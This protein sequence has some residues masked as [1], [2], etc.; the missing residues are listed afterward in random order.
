MAPFLIMLANIDL[1]PLSSVDGYGECGNLV[2][3]NVAASA[4]FKNNVP[5]NTIDNNL[6]TRWSNSASGSW[7][8]YDLGENKAICYL[9]IAW[10]KGNQ[11][12]YNFAIST[13]LDGSS[14][15][16]VHTGKSGKSTSLQRY[17]IPDTTTR[18]V[19][20]T[21]SGNSANSWAEITEVDIYGFV[22]DVVAP[23]VTAL[24][25]GGTFNAAQSIT[26]VA[27]EP[28]TIYFTTDSS[29]PTASSQ[30]YTGPLS[31]SSTTLLNYLAID[32]AGNSS[33]IK[34]EVY[35]I[36]T[37]LPAIQITRPAHGSSEY[38]GTII[39]EGTSSDN[40]GGSGLIAV[41][42]SLD[43]GTYTMAVPIVS[44]TWSSGWQASLDVT[45]EGT[46]SVTA[47][48]TDNAG[49][50][51]SN[52][53][54]IDT[55]L[56]KIYLAEFLPYV[57]TDT[58]VAIY[59]ELDADDFVK[60]RSI[61]GLLDGA[62]VQA[63][64]SLPGYHGVEYVAS[65]QVIDNAA[66]VK[67]M[68]F[69]FIE[70]NIESGL[71]PEEDSSD[72]VGAYER[73]ANAAHAAGLKLRATP[74]RA[75]T[76]TFGTQIAPYADYYLVQAQSLQ[77]RNTPVDYSDYVHSIVP[78][79]NAANPEMTVIVQVSANRGAGTG[80]TVVETMQM[81]LEATMD[82]ADGATVW[83]GNTTTNE[84]DQMVDWFQAEYSG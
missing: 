64:L 48:A 75:Y 68:G 50:Q 43:S 23:S 52:T 6:N 16:D 39:I 83:F 3:S 58:Q 71:S 81:C 21:I 49:N 65:Q 10:F 69:D 79:L 60:L 47:R 44:G 67:T 63:V 29:S 11:R 7:V 55:H 1:A 4:Y 74:A 36:D 56:P 35:T 78:N 8:R 30:R 41:E 77:D 80:L 15:T 19:K 54:L 25:S 34:T 66:Q 42:V 70:L 46:H 12:S 38:V 72:V 22:P 32:I 14:F 45:S 73:A 40:D 2:V 13:S 18:F 62:K 61:D 26:L 84:L 37:I 5:A 9:D 51:N 20:I 28:A 76:T 27:S 82:V 59:H 57:D 53:I 24:P 31:I 17:D 33:P